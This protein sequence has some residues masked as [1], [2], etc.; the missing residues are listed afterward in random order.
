M[1]NLKLGVS[2]SAYESWAK[3]TDMKTVRDLTSIDRFDVFESMG[4][5]GSDV[6]PPYEYVELLEVNDMDVFG[7]ETGTD[8][9]GAVA[10][11]FQGFA[12]N[13]TFILMKNIEN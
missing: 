6:K 5:L 4:L 13:P 7:E 3:E 12:D 8:T 2:K 9:M 1:F 10:K 11:Q